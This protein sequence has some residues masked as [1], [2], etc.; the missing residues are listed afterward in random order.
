MSVTRV[1]TSVLCPPASA[2][3]RTQS[4]SPRQSLPIVYSGVHYFL[5]ST[6]PVFIILGFVFP[7]LSYKGNYTLHIK[8]DLVECIW[9]S[10]VLLNVSVSHVFLMNAVLI[11]LYIAFTT[12]LLPLCLKISI[13]ILFFIFVSPRT[14]HTIN[15]SSS[16]EQHISSCRYVLINSSVRNS[17][18]SPTHN[19][20][21]KWRNMNALCYLGDSKFVF[22]THG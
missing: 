14:W 2:A 17:A 7:R 1:L 8:S 9:V 16:A 18:L 4:S 15:N 19:I 22:F 11:C 6:A 5:W 10:S 12:C 20:F 21:F 3:L 13:F